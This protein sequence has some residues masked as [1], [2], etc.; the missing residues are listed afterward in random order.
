MINGTCPFCTYCRIH[1]TTVHWG[2]AYFCCICSLIS[3]QS[4]GRT[5]SLSV[6][7]LA[8]P[9]V[10]SS[11]QITNCSFR[12]ASSHRWNQL[13]SSF[14]QPHCVL[15]LCMSQCHLIT[16]ITFVLTIYQLQTFTNDFLHSHSY[17]FRTA[18]TDLNLYCIKGALAF[19][20]FS[21]F[22]LHVLDKAEIGELMYEL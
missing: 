13:P 7:T 3:L 11:L 18:F 14:R 17:S 8:R 15:I 2:N 9:S 5:R 1:F 10:S 21:F 4:S 19:V 6:V 22:W 20:R 12:Y 16:V